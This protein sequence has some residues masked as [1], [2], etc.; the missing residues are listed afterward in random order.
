M[1]WRHALAYVALAAALAL[2][3]WST[4]PSAPPSDAFAAAALPAERAVEMVLIEAD[5][6]RLRVG[7]SAGG[8][9][10]LEPA[11]R[12]ITPDLMERLLAAVLHS[13][14]ETVAADAAP[15]DFGLDQ[16]RAR[17]TLWRRTEPPVVLILGADNPTATA[18]YGR[19]EGDPR[20]LLVGLDVWHYVT[21]A[22]R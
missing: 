7:R 5:G 22:M 19:L 15:G 4:A 9:D 20:V 6:Q 16:P 10:V 21:L 3:R 8:W 13:R 12:E 1:S 18:V 11:G 17:V 14:I 2:A